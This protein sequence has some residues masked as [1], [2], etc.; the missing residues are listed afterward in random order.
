MHLELLYDSRN[1]ES[2]GGC[3]EE[4]KG[5]FFGNFG[6]SANGGAAIDPSEQRA[7]SMRAGAL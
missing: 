7:A 4:L 1:V 6:G 3:S 2:G 5:M